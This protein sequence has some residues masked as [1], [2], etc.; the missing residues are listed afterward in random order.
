[1]KRLIVLTITLCIIVGM[2]PAGFAEEQ[3]YEWTWYK[4]FTKSIKV[5][6]DHL[7]PDVSWMDKDYEEDRLRLYMDE[8][9]R[10][11]YLSLTEQEML[12]RILDDYIDLLKES[13]EY[14]YSLEKDIDGK[15]KPTIDLTLQR[16]AYYQRDYRMYKA[17]EEVYQYFA[18]AQIESLIDLVTLGLVNEGDRVIQLNEVPTRSDGIIMAV[19]LLG[20]EDAALTGVYPSL[21]TGVPEYAKPYVDYASVV[22][23]LNPVTKESKWDDG[24]LSYEE[25]LR[26]LIRCLGYKVSDGSDK[27]SIETDRLA[28]S[29]DIS[30]AQ[31]LGTTYSSL[32]GTHVLPSET[33]LRNGDLISMVDL[34]MK[35][36]FKGTYE[37]VLDRLVEKQIVSKALKYY[38]DTKDYYDKHGDLQWVYGE[39]VSDFTKRLYMCV[40]DHEQVIYGSYFHDMNELGGSLDPQKDKIIGKIRISTYY[41]DE[42]QA[43]DIIEGIV[44]DFGLSK[45][46]AKRYAKSV[47]EEPFTRD[48]YEYGWGHEAEFNGLRVKT[49]YVDYNDIIVMELFK[50]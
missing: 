21:Y 26:F 44:A 29:Q 6:N 37:R 38:M 8:S 35:E 2:L 25:W 3:T 34:L 13:N 23:I 36:N 20:D 43:Q 16:S 49:H 15:T 4:E 1:M 12:T 48:K 18:P 28:Y 5:K 19:K 10:Q 50:Q 39:D 41:N 46:R 22:G 31:R 33:P 47:I 9:V 7:Y 27:D 11:G 42:S 17:G 32:K 40:Q 45:S 30:M 14:I 24:D